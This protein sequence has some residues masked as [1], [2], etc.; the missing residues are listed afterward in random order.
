MPNSDDAR[1][2]EVRQQVH[3][4]KSVQSV[5][6]WRSIWRVIGGVLITL[7]LLWAVWQMR[8]LV[9]MVLLA[10]FLSLA[11]EPGIRV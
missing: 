11:L 2:A 6:A 7:A 10:L 4:E 3:P 1:S 5:I 8:S 9:G